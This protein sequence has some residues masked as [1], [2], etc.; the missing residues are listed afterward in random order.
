MNF[1]DDDEPAGDRRPIADDGPFTL[2]VDGET[3]TVTLRADG[4]CD[5]DWN[6]GPNEGYGFSSSRT[7]VAG[8]PY[9][10]LPANTVD[11]HRDSI[12][13]FLGLI[14]PETGYIGD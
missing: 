10:V 11:E 7:R 6:S 14:N 4:G 1:A 5:Y 8:D 13:N 12:R 2:I 9:A 3:F